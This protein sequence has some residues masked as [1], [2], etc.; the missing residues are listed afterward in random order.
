MTAFDQRADSQEWIAVA[1][2]E[3]AG[4][5]SVDVGRMR[6]VLVP[7]NE[8]ICRRHGK[9]RRRRYFRLM[10]RSSHK[11]KHA[12]VDVSGLDL[13]DDVGLKIRDQLVCVRVAAIDAITQMLEQPLEQKQK[14]RLAGKH[15]IR[16]NDQ[17]RIVFRWT[18]AGPEDVEIID[19]H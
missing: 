3:D 10:Q 19:Y 4:E 14:A 12:P 7:I 11:G 8:L 16:I 18:D 15:S 9:L 17:W 1:R 13:R 5:S 2:F 6:P